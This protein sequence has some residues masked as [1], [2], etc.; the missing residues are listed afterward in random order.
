MGKCLI[1]L[2]NIIYIIVKKV[3]EL[4]VYLLINQIL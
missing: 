1:T 4:N 2:F 3:D